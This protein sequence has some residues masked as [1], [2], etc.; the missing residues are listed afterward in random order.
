MPK[1]AFRRAWTIWSTK[2]GPTRT[3]NSG[4]LLSGMAHVRSGPP[5]TYRQ[6]ATVSLFLRSA[7]NRLP[8]PPPQ[9]R[10]T[11]PHSGRSLYARIMR[12]SLGR[13]QMQRTNPYLLQGH[14][15]TWMQFSGSNILPLLRN[16]LRPSA[17]TFHVLRALHR[18]QFDCFC[19]GLRQ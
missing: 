12:N 15:L 5:E 13:C 9:R 6:L 16:S 3:H 11:I 19:H 17:R 10:T 1:R 14:D 4:W 2:A 7:R 18:I 8:W